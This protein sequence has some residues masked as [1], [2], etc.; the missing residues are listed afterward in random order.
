MT[1][2]TYR[3]NQCK[4]II[5]ENRNLREEMYKK[6]DEGNKEFQKMNE[7]N[8]LKFNI[9]NFHRDQEKEENRKKDLE[10]SQKQKFRSHN[11]DIC[12]EMIDLII[13]ISDK[14]Y[15]YQQIN[16]VEEI[17]HRVWREWT[18]LFK[19]NQSVLYKPEEEE[20]AEI[21]QEAEE[22][23]EEKKEE[24]ENKEEAK[25]VENKEEN[26][27]E[28]KKEG[29]N[30]EEKKDQAEKEDESIHIDINSRYNKTFYSIF[31]TG[32]TTCTKLDQ[33]LD[34]NEFYEYQNNKGQWNPELIPESAFITLKPDDLTFNYTAPT[35]NQEPTKKEKGGKNVN[36]AK[37]GNDKAKVENIEEMMKLED[38]KD[39]VIPKENIK[40]CLFGDLIGILIDLKYDEEK[41]KYQEERQSQKN[42][43]RYIPI[44]IALIGK[45]FSG[46]RTQA[47]ILSENFPMKI[48]DLGHL[49]QEALNLLNSKR[50]TTTTNKFLLTN[51][52]KNKTQ[53]KEALPQSQ[54]PEGG[55]HQQQN[56][57]N[58]D[59]NNK[60]QGDQVAQMRNEQA[61]EEIKYARIK[62]L[63][64]EIKLRLGEGEGVPDEI[65]AELL[66]EY[67]KLDFPPKEDYEVTSEII[68]RV[69]RKEK[70]YKKTKN[71]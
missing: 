31:N 45:D 71:I 26:K 53:Q 59:A 67:I 57:Q 3:V 40:N 17:D 34:E 50:E 36:P 23:K 11:S 35:T 21:K 42:L 66:C 5:K 27:E 13:D 44:K 49:V 47:K 15:E 24:V 70:V 2:E 69:S 30:Q 10:I 6:R 18:N 55:E 14:A 1:Y 58:N 37:G 43:F 60:T 25:E 12:K 61:A 63:A 41:K 54:S 48:Y 51:S 32:D 29:E 64:R 46:K 62:E 33:I 22:N 16:D 9:E 68:E 7:E 8:Y 56:N 65:Y 4:N 20:K 52:M 39:L 28:E 38:P 19:N